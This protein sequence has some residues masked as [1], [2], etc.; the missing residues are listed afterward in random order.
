MKPTQNTTLTRDT[1]GALHALYGTATDGD[2]DLYL[3]AMALVERAAQTG[4]LP[5][6][7]D[8]MEWGTSGRE[9]GKRIGDA[10]HH[11]IYDISADGRH[12]LVCVRAVEGSRYGQ[13]TTEKTYYLVSR[14]GRGAHVTEASK[15]VAAKAA[16]AAGNTLGMAIAV[17]TGKR[18]APAPKCMAPR[19][20][21]KIVRRDG[22]RFV[23]VWDESEWS[24]GKTRTEAASPDHNGG[25]YFYASID[26]AIRQAVERETF[27]DARQYHDLS[28]IEVE[29]SGREFGA[30]KRCATRIKPLR[31][32]CAII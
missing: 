28:I 6:A 10:Q 22:E 26:E 17:V 18:P 9:R 8:D 27:G 23:S 1:Y 30:I 31:E 29:A 13:K 19:T 7:Y 16:K 15:A 32:V 3:A 24:I 14:H 4:K 11:E 21:Y 5:R 12:V 20:G 2:R 25:F